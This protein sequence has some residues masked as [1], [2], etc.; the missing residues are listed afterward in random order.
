VHVSCIWQ[1]LC[2]R[3]MFRSRLDCFRGDGLTV[4]CS[5]CCMPRISVIMLCFEF[6]PSWN[7]A[8]ALFNSICS[9]FRRRS[10]VLTK[11]AK[12]CISSISAA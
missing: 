5:V 2:G 3:V 1:S 7:L 4:V 6:F 11:V 9:C 12:C 8:G 10:G